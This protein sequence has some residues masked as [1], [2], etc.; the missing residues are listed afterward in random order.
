MV[1]RH[2]RTIQRGISMQ[3]ESDPFFF[4]FSPRQGT[5]GCG[6][7]R[8]Y[9]ACGQCWVGEHFFVCAGLSVEPNLAC[10]ITAPCQERGWRGCGF[11]ILSKAKPSKWPPWQPLRDDCAVVIWKAKMWSLCLRPISHIGLQITP[12]SPVKRETGSWNPVTLPKRLWTAQNAVVY[13]LLPPCQ[14]NLSVWHLFL[15]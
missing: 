8:G 12:L 15:L 7:H 4:T 3:S 9:R 6:R 2:G 1:L 14:K 11:I 13:T 5:E 10:S